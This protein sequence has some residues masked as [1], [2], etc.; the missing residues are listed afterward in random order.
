MEPRIQYAQTSDGVNIAYCVAGEGSELA[1]PPA[2]AIYEALARL[3]S[4]GPSIV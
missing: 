1:F 4:V 2:V 3:V